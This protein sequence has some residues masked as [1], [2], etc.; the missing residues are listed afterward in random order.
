MSQEQNVTA[1]PDYSSLIG[2]PVTNQDDE[3]LGTVQALFADDRSEVP[4][5][6][7]V[8]SGL[9]GRRHTLVPLAQARFEDGRLLV[10][11]T[12]DDLRTALHHD[13]DVPLTAEEEQTLFDHYNVGYSDADTPGP[14]TGVEADD[15]GLTGTPGS[16]AHPVEPEDVALPAA[17]VPG[18]PGL[19]RAEL[20]TRLRRFVG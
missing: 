8:H 1:L 15:T 10:P 9:F 2:A 14:H 13:P 19:P 3:K 4:T 18:V 12:D 6:V 7:A 11:Y 16:G 17:E 20:R 5:W